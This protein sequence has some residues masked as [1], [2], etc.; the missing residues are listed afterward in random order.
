VFGALFVW[1]LLSSRGGVVVLGPCLSSLGSVFWSRL[2]SCV[3]LGRIEWGW[4]YFVT[5]AMKV[6]FICVKIKKIN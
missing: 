2:A 6:R 1:V 3:S 5:L 4:L